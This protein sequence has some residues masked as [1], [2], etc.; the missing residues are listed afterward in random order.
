MSLNTVTKSSPSL[1]S[2]PPK[3]KTKSITQKLAEFADT[4]QIGWKRNNQRKIR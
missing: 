1:N 4:E 2:V 3:P